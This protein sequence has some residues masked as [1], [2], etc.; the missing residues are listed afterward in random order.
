MPHRYEIVSHTA[1]TGI[2]T[3]GATLGEA[4]GNAAFAMFDLMFDLSE[5]T[6]EMTISFDLEAESPTELLVDVLS[7]LLWRSET[8]DLAFTDVGVHETGLHAS[9]R[10]A[11]ADARELELRGPPVKAVTYHQLRCERIGDRWAIRVIFDV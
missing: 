2:E 10:A 4:I 5:V 6:P 11:A 7:E 1:D 3:E 8:G 9:V